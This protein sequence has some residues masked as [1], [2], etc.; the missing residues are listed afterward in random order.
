MKKNKHNKKRNTAFLYEV[1]IKEMTKAIISKDQ[2]RKLCVVSILKEFFNPNAILRTELSLYNTLLE[3]SG[4]DIYTAEK[5]V[6][7]VREA[8][9]KLD[10]QQVHSAQGSLIKRVNKD[11]TKSV[12]VNFVSNYK[13]MATLS[14]LFDVDLSAASIKRNVLLEHQIVKNLT[15]VKTNEPQK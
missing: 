7:N 3:T 10:Q 14:Q 4:L 5:L 9:S 13:S 6:Y 12:F 1:L 8:H 15:L 2:K 11:L